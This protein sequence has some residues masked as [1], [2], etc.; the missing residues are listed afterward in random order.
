MGSQIIG[1]S[2]SCLC[3]LAEIDVTHSAVLFGCTENTV[4]VHSKQNYCLFSNLRVLANHKAFEIR[5]YVTKI[6]TLMSMDSNQSSKY[7][8]TEDIL[9]LIQLLMC[10]GDISKYSF[11]CLGNLAVDEYFQHVIAHND[12]IIA[13]NRGLSKRIE[14]FSVDETITKDLAGRLLCHL[15]ANSEEVAFQVSFKIGLF[16]NLC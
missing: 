15:A 1:L 7:F 5:L 12:G 13:T 4:S 2:L 9:T 6:Y 10:G 11:A 16:E 3:N 8:V 14:Q